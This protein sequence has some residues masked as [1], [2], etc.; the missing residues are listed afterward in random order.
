M[1]DLPFCRRENLL[2][3]YFVAS[4]IISGLDYSNAMSKASQF[5]V[6][7]SVGTWV[8]VPGITT[9]MIEK[10]QARVVEV[11]VINPNTEYNECLVLL[12]V[13][14]PS[15]NFG[16]SFTMMLTSM[17]GNDVSTALKVRLIDIE[18]IGN[19]ANEFVSPKKNIDDLR[20]IAGVKEKRPLVLNMIK[21]C[22]GFSA[23]AGAELFR[24]VALGGVDL[25]KDDE[26][27]GNTKYN[28][29]KNRCD[30][31]IKASKQAYETTGKPT[32]YLPNIS[33]SPKDMID[34]AKAA[35]DA[36]AK[37]CL[38]NYVLGGIDSGKDL[39]EEFGDKLFIMGHYAG[40]ACFDG[41]SSGISD[42]VMLGILPRLS[43][44]NAIMTMYPNFNDPKSVN[45]FIKTVQSQKL[46]IPNLNPIVSAIGG[47]ITPINQK[48]VQSLVG[49][50]SII[51]IGGAIQGHPLG[52]TAGAKT[53]MN[54]VKASF[55]GIELNELAKTDSALQTAIS[56]WQKRI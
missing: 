7:Q 3:D 30:A 19:A 10:Y 36:G 42:S 27:L 34:N 4:Y 35:I 2:G 55:N 22:L 52:T 13:A 32:I 15:I 16:G 5:A 28:T 33:G 37:A 45:N 40:V 20:K 43:G 49:P 6:G 24:E 8:K 29:I 14:F 17:V 39:V 50:D 18:I 54:A 12:K 41:E 1:F 9:E 11:N 51:G 56:L 26:L 38:V 25:I 46:D 44:L 21:P 23:E 47:G 48:Q 53:A 31:Y